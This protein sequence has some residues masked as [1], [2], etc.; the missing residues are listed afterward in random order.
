MSTIQVKDKFFKPFISSDEIQKAVCQVADKI[1]KDLAGKNPIFICVLNGAF[2][3]AADLYKNITIDSEITFMR[4][5]SYDGMQTTGK[6]KAISGLMEDIKDRTVVVV[7]DIVDTGYTMKN[8]IEQLKE[9][10]AKEVKIATL[11]HKPEALKVE[12]DLDYVALN[13]PNAFIV[14]YGLDYD[15]LGRN[16]KDIYVIA[17]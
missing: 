10:G 4:M 3:F 11:L 14:G 2:M 17:E 13:I 9:K 5:K 8:I 6:V 1:N 7:E 16:L 15:E 12:L